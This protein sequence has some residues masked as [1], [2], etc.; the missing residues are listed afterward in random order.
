M[1][2]LTN[3][4][5]VPEETVRR[6]CK[7]FSTK[8]E[9]VLSAGLLIIPIYSIFHQCLY[10]K[11]RQYIIQ[12]ARIYL[13]YEMQVIFITHLHQVNICLYEIH[14]FAEGDD[15]RIVLFQSVAQHVGK[16]VDIILC[17]FRP[18]SYQRLQGIERIEQHV[19]IQLVFQCLVLVAYIL[20]LQL[21]VLQRQYSS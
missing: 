12:I 11:W 6:G 17:P 5:P 7:T 20:S 3:P 13:N 4:M 15:M 8:R 14:F 1:A 10:G 16:L 9:N 21:P 18:L 19:R 2:R